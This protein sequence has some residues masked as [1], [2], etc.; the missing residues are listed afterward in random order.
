MKRFVFLPL[1]LILLCVRSVSAQPVVKVAVL[2][3]SDQP[4]VYQH[5][6]NSIRDSIAEVQSFFASEMLSLLM[7]LQT[8]EI[9]LQHMNWGMRLVSMNILILAKIIS[10]SR[11]R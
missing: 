11:M 2:R 7:D 8:T 3:A 1:L 5:E 9:E 10:W 6:V 4:V